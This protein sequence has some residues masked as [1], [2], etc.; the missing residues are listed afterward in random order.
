MTARHSIVLPAPTERVFAALTQPGHITRWWG[1]DAVYWMTN[2]Q[3]ELRP[4]GVAKYGGT[5]TN[6]DSVSG[7]SAGREFLGA[8]VT[9]AVDAPHML[10]YTRRYTDGIPCTEETVI[11][12]ELEPC[13]SGTR[14]T[15]THTGFAT[16]EM[17]E[18]HKHGW[19][20]AFA[21]LEAYL[22]H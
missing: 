9:R 12:Y 17:S 19:E 6:N 5:F 20:R 18:L 14:L 2:V 22:K 13:D 1:E 8:G 16:E 21:W 4:G 7:S 15:V 11:R 3:H 10:E